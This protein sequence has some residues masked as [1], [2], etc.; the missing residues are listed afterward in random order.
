MSLDNKDG[1]A[2]PMMDG[3]AGAKGGG[4]DTAKDAAASAVASTSDKSVPLF[5]PPPLMRFRFHPC[6]LL[7]SPRWRTN[8]AKSKIRNARI[9]DGR[10]NLRRFHGCARGSWD[11][12]DVWA[13]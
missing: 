5:P 8:R 13:R 1:T 11:N 2:P 6:R 7:S 12:D 3:G 9:M 10:E 4:Y